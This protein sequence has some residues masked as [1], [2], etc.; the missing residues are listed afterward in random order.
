MLT[1]FINNTENDIVI[2]MTQNII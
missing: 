2:M 1:T